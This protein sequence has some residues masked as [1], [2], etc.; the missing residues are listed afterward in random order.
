MRKIELFCIGAR[1]CASSTPSD[2][3][4]ATWPLRDTIMTTPGI[5][6]FCMSA[7]MRAVSASRRSLEKPPAPCGGRPAQPASAA[8][9]MPINR[10][11]IIVFLSI[12]LEERRDELL[13]RFLRRLG[14]GRVVPDM[15][16]ALYAGILVGE[17]L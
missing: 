8:S 14:G 11:R 10:L 3:E 15:R 6:P 4:Y 7:C 1:L 16:V 13:Q 17:G 12:L 9:A 5:W 2:C